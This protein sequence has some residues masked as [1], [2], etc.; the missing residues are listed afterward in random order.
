MIG[1][2]AGQTRGRS[3]MISAASVNAT[4][5]PFPGLDLLSG[6]SL[7]ASKSHRPACSSTVGL[8]CQWCSYREVEM[9]IV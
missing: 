8:H 6:V 2:G 1:Q 7:D 3:E 5:F 9:P 4:L